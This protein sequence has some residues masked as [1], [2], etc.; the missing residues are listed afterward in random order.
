MT[1]TNLSGLTCL[2]ILACACS[3][4][5]SPPADPAGAST[6]QPDAMP[7]VDYGHSSRLSLDWHGV[8]SGVTPCADCPGIR[9]TV[10]LHADG[11]F[12]RTLVYLERSTEPHA[13]SGT[14]VWNAAG[15]AVTLEDGGDGQQ[16][17]V[18]E[19]VLFHLDQDGNRITGDLAGSYV[20]HKHLEDPGIEGG[21]WTLT[22]LGGQ[23]VA[24]EST[25]R[26]AFLMLD[27]ENAV[28]SGNSSCNSFSGGYAIKSGNRINFNENFAV[29]MMACPN[30]SMEEQFLD[31][32][33]N[34]DN[35]AIADGVLSLNRARMAPLARF[36]V[37]E[38]EAGSSD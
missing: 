15:S 13:A 38:G 32:L 31:V 20:L 26:G 17:M 8:Y 5:G 14:F 6:P 28:A 18:G 19:N 27:A 33:R 1:K 36:E 21:K 12:E 22:E 30:M 23:P 9:T 25:A 10:T 11:R 34:A 37:A 29:T 2:L 3:Q 16:Y 24:A 35:Y 7:T 4:E